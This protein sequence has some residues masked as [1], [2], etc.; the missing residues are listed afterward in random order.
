MSD[1]NIRS[2]KRALTRFAIHSAVQ[3]GHAVYAFSAKI[4][5]KLNR[6]GIAGGPNS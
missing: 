6:P 2:A 5:R 3:D 1:R 4:S